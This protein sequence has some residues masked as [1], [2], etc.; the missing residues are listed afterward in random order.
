MNLSKLQLEL[1]EEKIDIDLYEWSPSI[2]SKEIDTNFSV[3]RSLQNPSQYVDLRI[4]RIC[5]LEKD[6][7]RIVLQAFTKRQLQYR[8]ANPRRKTQS[9][10]RE[11]WYFNLSDEEQNLINLI[12]KPRFY[13]G[14]PHDS[15]DIDKL[16]EYEKKRQECKKKINIRTLFSGLRRRVKD[17]D[18]QIDTNDY[19]LV[20]E[21]NITDAFRVSTI[22]SA[23]VNAFDRRYYYTYSY[24]L[25]FNNQYVFLGVNYP[26]LINF[27]P[28]WFVYNEMNID[29]SLDV[30]LDCHQCTMSRLI[31]IVKDIEVYW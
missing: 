13:N 31:E 9:Q 12:E 8:Y 17:V 20:C 4:R 23:N 16:M 21:S 18:A 5:E 15:N 25:S 10:S 7:Q 30:M 19:R 24:G 22:F 27:I 6:Q 28:N 29:S 3:L 26:G 11:A 2:I 1:I 14:H